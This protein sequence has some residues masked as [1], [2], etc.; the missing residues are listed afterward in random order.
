MCPMLTQSAC[1]GPRSR[2][3][4][5]R[6]PTGGRSEQREGGAARAGQAEDGRARHS[7]SRTADTSQARPPSRVRAGGRM[8]PSWAM[9]SF[10][11]TRAEA[12]L[13]GP[14]VPR[15][16]GAPARRSPSVDEQKSKFIHNGDTETYEL[17]DDQTEWIRAENYLRYGIPPETAHES[18]DDH[19]L[20]AEIEADW[21]MLD[22]VREYQEPQV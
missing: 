19:L 18:D 13:R 5:V 16:G 14:Q 6:G 10:R 2:P 7:C 4:N 3:S 22:A 1:C 12:T 15:N 21:A 17:S 20:W 8:R 11:R 9:P